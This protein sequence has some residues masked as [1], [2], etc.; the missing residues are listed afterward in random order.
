[1]SVVS[2]S[3]LYHHSKN[4]SLSSFQAASLFD[5]CKRPSTPLHRETNTADNRL[6]TTMSKYIAAY[7]QIPKQIFPVSPD[8]MVKL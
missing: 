7:K 8:K 5:Y 3:S 2:F 1:M 4:T 6:T